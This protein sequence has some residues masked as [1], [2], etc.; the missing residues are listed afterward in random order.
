MREVLIVTG[1]LVLSMA[2]RSY[3][4]P[5][6]VRL[7]ILAIFVAT[8]LA[9]FF[10][11]GW[12]LAGI[13]AALAWLLLPWVEILTRVRRLRLP[14]Q[15]ELREMPPPPSQQFPALSE[16]TDEVEAEGF[17]HLEDT[18]WEWDGFRQ[19]FRI[20]FREEDRAVAA[21]C[22]SEQQEV[23]FFYLSITSRTS[24]G[25]TLLTW[26]YPFSRSMVLP[27]SVRI[28]PDPNSDAFG[29]LS[30]SHRSFVRRQGVTTSTLKTFDAAAVLNA[31]QEEMRTQ[32]DYNVKLG[33]LKRVGDGFVRYS[34]RGM[35]F[36]W[37]QFLVDF[38]KLR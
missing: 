38:V 32:I 13:A 27:P 37:R 12:H 14:M 24:E 31:I 5:L 8:Y 25:N 1:I 3:R 30:M 4:T 23:S 10:L 18:G 22:L 11:T 36:L 26:N 15:K 28:N 19:F 33:L 2:L 21:I 7:S 6:T 16:L 20:F 17:E 29:Q 34:W 35:F 9:V